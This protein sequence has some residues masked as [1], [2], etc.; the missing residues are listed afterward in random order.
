[1]SHFT[2]SRVTLGVMDAPPGMEPR[3]KAGRRRRPA[4]IH[5]R[6]QRMRDDYTLRLRQ[7]LDDVRPSYTTPLARNGFICGAQDAKQDATRERR[8][9]RTW[10]ELEDG[11]RR[12]CG[13]PGC[14]HRERTGR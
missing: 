6:A 9:R 11:M 12:P 4:S 5:D 1:V 3:H 13:R 14:K 8:V 10:E 2:V 7:P